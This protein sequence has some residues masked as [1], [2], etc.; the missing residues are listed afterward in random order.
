MIGQVEREKPTTFEK[1]K[2]GMLPWQHACFF[3]DLISN[4]EMISN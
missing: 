4:E 1:K 2:K 3:L